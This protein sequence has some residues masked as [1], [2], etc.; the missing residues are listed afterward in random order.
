MIKLKHKHH[1][2]PRHAGGTDDPSNLIELTIEEH[3]EAHRVL[4]ETYGSIED[5]L[6]W[7]GLSGQIGKDEI[8]LQLSKSRKGIKK[9]KGH[10]EKVS[11]FR[12]TF[13]YSEESKKKM[14]D[15]KKGKLPR[16]YFVEMAKRNVG[17][18]QTEYQKQKVAS[19]FSKTWSITSPTGETM[20]IVNL[21][22]FCIENNLDSGNMSR[23][24]H[25]GWKCRKIEI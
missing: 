21:R 8:L 16:E 4:Y 25:K 24:K 10:G 5:K 9:P 12:K 11:A 3:A 20:M 17:R 22:K 1:I 19:M 23:G 6:A 14:S 13:T 18:K 7:M 15:A 2:I